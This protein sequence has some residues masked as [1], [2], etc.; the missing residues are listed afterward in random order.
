MLPARK[1][2]G[3]F[4][5]ELL[6]TVDWCLRLNHLERPQSVFTLQKALLGEK[7]PEYQG[8]APMLEQLKGALLRLAGR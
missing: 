6:D 7:A 8:E 1:A 4:T 3:G 5:S 2:G